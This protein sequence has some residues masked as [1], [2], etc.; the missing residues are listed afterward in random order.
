MLK[1][2][3]KPL[4]FFLLF[5]IPMHLF[6]QLQI[7]AGGVPVQLVQNILVGSGVTV[8]NVTY[9]GAPTAIGSFTTGGMPT[10]LG[11]SSGLI[12]SSGNVTDAIGPN[13]LASTTTAHNTPGDAL[14]NSILPAGQMT[15][16]AAILEFDFVPLSDTIKFQYV[17]GSEEYP[18][19]LNSFNDVFGFFVSGGYNPSTWLPYVNQNI[20]IIPG[21]TLPV[22]IDNVNNGPNNTGPC[23][24]CA[25]YVHNV[26]GTSV[27]YDGMTTVL[28]AYLPVI[29][30]V[31]YHLKLAVADVNDQAYD[32]G[33]FLKENSFVS[34][35]V[36]L[37]TSTSKPG[38][39]SVA[40]EGCNDAIVTFRI[41]D[42]ATAPRD[43]FYSIGGSAQ[44]GIDYVQ[45]PNNVT[46]P[47]GQDSVNLVISPILDSI[48]EPLEKVRLIVNTSFCTT[49]TIYVPIKDYTPLDPYQTSNDTVICATFATLTTGDTNGLPPYSYQWNTGDSL[50]TITV[51]PSVTSLYT[52]QIT[53]I[54]NQSHTDSVLVT[55]SKP[56]IATT[57]DTI[58]KGDDATVSASAVGA[59][60]YEWDTGTLTPSFNISPPV[61]TQYTVIVTDTLGC[62]DTADAWVEV[63]PLPVPIITNDA[64]ICH[65]DSMDVSVSG[66][67]DYIWNTGAITSV[68]TVSPS[69]ATTYSVTVTD[70]NNC[71]NDTSMRIEVIPMPQPIIT[72]E[73]DTICRGATIT[74]EAS[75]GETYLWDNGQTSASI[76]VSP[77][78]STAYTVTATNSLNGVNCSDAYTFNLGVK[79]C[80]R[81]FV[82]SAF[83]PDG[84]NINDDFGPEGVFTSLEKFEVYIFDR[85][86]RMIFYSND[87]GLRWNG[88]DG[89][90]KPAPNAVYIYRMIIKE[91]Y[92]D[93]YELFGS[94][95]LLR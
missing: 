85:T 17:F 72:A 48:P 21:T 94:V 74:L 95:T 58:C 35:N 7:T 38:I 77:P 14:L 79:R 69:V 36:Q 57:G 81:F 28:T 62:K 10:N 59:I 65:G 45:I 41:P 71:E 56:V 5:S 49:D 78:V 8:T 43:I 86:G 29:P 92:S 89:D 64:T 39:D 3:F 19:W 84:D 52:V 11:F 4:I 47:A 76:V 53:D 63:N 37:F 18:E 40:I 31:P 1:R 15:Y 90:G 75:G 91:T 23:V 73:A 42:P 70:N 33:V 51:Y 27:E 67:A 68:I 83:S 12:L 55:V 80:N 30:C 16:D 13:S 2:V 61:S 34:D 9:T 20:A 46:I 6:A 25:Y 66:G 82:P 54:C 60:S 87:P 44:N 24:N 50:Q 32:S 22:S 88:D 93:E 26:G